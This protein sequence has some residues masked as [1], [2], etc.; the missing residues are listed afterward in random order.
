[1]T[2]KRYTACCG[3]YCPD[4]IPANK[5]LFAL[6]GKLDGMLAE[7]DFAKYADYKAAGGNAAFA[8]YATFA[9]VLQAIRGLECRALCCDGGNKAGC[10]VRQCVVAK[11]YAGCWECDGFRECG[12][13]APMKLNHLDLDHN[14]TMIREHGAE[15]WAPKRGRHY[16][17]DTVPRKS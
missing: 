16:H 6:A 11:G 17:W 7:L 9:E 8:G 10:A 13:L 3:L 5:E 14:L 2:D 15:E 1:M 4:C 12:L